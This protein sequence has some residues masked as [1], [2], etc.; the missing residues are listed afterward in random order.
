ML[1]APSMRPGEPVTAGLSAGPGA[2]P[3][4]LNID[5]REA[6]TARLKKW[7]PMLQPVI[8]EPDTPDSVKMLY[9]YMRG[10]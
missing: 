9:R 2:G 4:V 7:L 8:N 6:E 1:S 10:V 3:E 5:P